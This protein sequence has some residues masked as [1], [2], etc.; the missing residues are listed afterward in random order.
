MFRR[1]VISCTCFSNACL[2]VLLLEQQQAVF[3]MLEM[4]KEAE[5]VFSRGYP[6]TL[7]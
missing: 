2:L 6:L 3:D 5:H 4:F 1:V 7:R